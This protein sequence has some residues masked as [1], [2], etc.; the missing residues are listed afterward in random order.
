M[1]KIFLGLS[2]LLG[3]CDGTI[4]TSSCFVRGTLVRTP[5][6]DVPIEDLAVGDEVLSFRPED[7]AV[8]R[9]RV[10]ATLRNVARRVRVLTIS[11]RTIVTTDEHPFWEAERRAW[12]SA[13][14][15]ARGAV[16]VQLRAD[17][18]TYPA[19][20]EAVHDEMRLETV[21]NLTVEGPEHT[22]FAGGIAVHN[23]SQLP[24]P[25]LPLTFVNETGAS[26]AITTRSAEG[27]AVAA[28]FLEGGA[29]L[30]IDPV[31]QPGQDEL[32]VV[33]QDRSIALPRARIDVTGRGSR[34]AVFLGLPGDRRYLV[35]GQGEVRLRAGEPVAGRGV[36][37]VA[38]AAGRATCA[39]GATESAFS[40][41]EER[42]RLDGARLK[43]KT[44]VDG[45]LSLAFESASDVSR[46]RLCIPEAAWPFAIDEE[47]SIDTRPEDGSFY[48]N[49]DAHELSV[50]RQRGPVDGFELAWEETCF[51]ADPCGVPRAPVTLR[52]SGVSLAPGDSATM[53]DGRT[54]WFFGGHVR[55]VSFASC[56]ADEGRTE[57]A[58]VAVVR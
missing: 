36:Q 27:L 26:V 41:P 55:P 1:R 13:G 22:Y 52:R 42:V 50:F 54:L 7:G 37:L 6:G 17:G 21:F 5:R 32:H 58:V 51:L 10:L 24:Q 34:E 15:L 40:V 45:C 23:K 20:I 38:L 39:E 4:G 33:L 8:V 16:L 30:A 56:P 47:L 25:E 3:G 9:R 48:A 49:S 44:V 11:G 19:A 2:F 53:D 43:E 46:L 14:D 28:R 12:I 57:G 29:P 31:L 35:L 18:T